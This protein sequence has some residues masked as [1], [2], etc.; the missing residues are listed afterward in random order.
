MAGGDYQSCDLCGG[1]SFYDANLGWD[2]NEEDAPN[3]LWGRGDVAALCMTCAKTHKCIVVHMT[4]EEREARK[5]EW[6][7]H[8]ERIKARKAKVTP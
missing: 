2:L 6:E 7:D 3:G 1:K 4:Q 8:R 5:K